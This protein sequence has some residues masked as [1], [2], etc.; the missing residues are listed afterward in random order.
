MRSR[1]ELPDEEPDVLPEML[2]LRLPEVEPTLSRPL[3]ELLELPE[4]DPEL[5][6]PPIP[7]LRSMPDEPVELRLRPCSSKSRV[8][9]W[10]PLL[11]PMFLLSAIEPS[12]F[13]VSVRPGLASLRPRRTRCD[14]RGHSARASRPTV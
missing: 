12:A 6:E 13:G 8:F 5:L 3:C 4:L 1:P 9:P 7:L 14:D 10:L 2:P 11:P